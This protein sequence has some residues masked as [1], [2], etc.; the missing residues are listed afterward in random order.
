[1]LGYDYL[2]VSIFWFY[3]D[4]LVFVEIHATS[5]WTTST[6]YIFQIIIHA[7]WSNDG[8]VGFSSSILANECCWL[9]FILS[10]T[11][12]C[13]VRKPLCG[14]RFCVLTGKKTQKFIKLNSMEKST[15]KVVIAYRENWSKL[16][17][18][19]FS[20]CRVLLHCQRWF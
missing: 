16:F 7:W 4:F 1:M 10:V 19:I 8:L 13:V 5:K 17:K 12:C 11:H 9:H 3:F 6:T 14:S 2:C 18:W 15:K 20:M